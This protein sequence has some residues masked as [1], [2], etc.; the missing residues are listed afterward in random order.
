MCGSYRVA[1]AYHNLKPKPLLVTSDELGPDGQPKQYQ[2][3]TEPPDSCL[4]NS[5]S[6]AMPPAEHLHHTCQVCGYDW[7]GSPYYATDEGKAELTDA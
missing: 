5:D 1:L 7:A 3:G 2:Y 6:E 4:K